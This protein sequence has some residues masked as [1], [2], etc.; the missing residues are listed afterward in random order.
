VR[1]CLRSKAC[2]S[3]VGAHFRLGRSPVQ[4]TLLRQPTFP[5]IRDR[6]PSL[7]RSHRRANLCRIGRAVSSGGGFTQGRTVGRLLNW[8]HR[9]A[10][11]PVTTRG[12]VSV[13]APRLRVGSLGCAPPKLTIRV[14]PRRPA[15]RHVAI[16]DHVTARDPQLPP[17]HLHVP[18]RRGR[19]DASW[20]HLRWAKRPGA[21][22][23]RSCC[24]CV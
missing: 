4:R 22:I 13:H 18:P 2:A 10:D 15:R 19:V 11:R 21:G 3:E 23:G 20:W 9:P 5:Q 12:H 8:S 6:P 14:R 1:K 7:T 24:V 17:Q 16:G